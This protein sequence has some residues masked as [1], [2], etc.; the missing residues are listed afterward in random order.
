MYENDFEDEIVNNKNKIEGQQPINTQTK[1]DAIARST[2]RSWF[3]LKD[4][5]KG[6]NDIQNYH[7]ELSTIVDVKHQEDGDENK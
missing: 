3:D 5:D 2:T 4:D 1:F 7:P 6:G